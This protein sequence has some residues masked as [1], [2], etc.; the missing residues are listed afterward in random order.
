MIADGLTY[1]LF[2]STLS[3]TVDQFTLDITGIN[4]PTDTEGGRYGVQLFAFNQPGSRVTTG[5]LSGFTYE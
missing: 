4:G 5:S 1:T 3:P 2:E